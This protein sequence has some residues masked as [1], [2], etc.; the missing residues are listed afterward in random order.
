MGLLSAEEAY[1]SKKNY[2]LES[3][4]E[5]YSDEK[6]M[7][8]LLLHLKKYLKDNKVKFSIE[9]DS[10]IRHTRSNQQG[11]ISLGKEAVDAYIENLYIEEQ[12]GLNILIARMEQHH[13]LKLQ[14]SLFLVTTKE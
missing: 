2:H 11:K 14:L 9:V 6:H 5:K 4:I 8:A 3:A 10:I 7:T 1:N 12:S 13:S